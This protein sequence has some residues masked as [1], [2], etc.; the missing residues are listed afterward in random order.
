MILRKLYQL[1]RI[2]NNPWKDIEVLRKQQYLK[3]RKMIS[4]AYE[5]VPFYHK[6]FK[7]AGIRPEDIRTLADIKKIPITYKSD[8][9]ARSEEFLARGYD[10][11][12][13]RVRY[14][15]G[16][17]GNPHR[18]FFSK[19]ADDF[20]HATDL[21]SM[22]QN[23]YRL[24]HKSFELSHPRHIGRPTIP[25]RLGLHRV[26]LASIFET[27]ERMAC[28]IREYQPMF[29]K[30]YPSMLR[31]IAAKIEQGENLGVRKIFTT[32]ELL[33][34]SDRKLIMES[35]KADVIDL[36]GSVEFPRVAWECEKH[37]GY[38]IDIDS[39]VFELTKGGEVIE[40][41]QGD[42]TITGLYNK[43]MPL[44]RYNV[45]DIGR[46][47]RGLRCGC[48][49]S[50]PLLHSI[51]GRSNDRI[52]LPSGREVDPLTLYSVEDLIGVKSF[53]IIQVKPNAFQVIYTNLPGS[54]IVEQSFRKAIQNACGNEKVKVT[55]K[56]ADSLPRDPSGKFRAV[57]SRVRRQ[58]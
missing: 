27:P 33:S 56:R 7:E 21:R 25:Q 52:I 48:G 19:S 18:L 2:K 49:R 15:S 28:H 43:A 6:L 39:V 23:G 37:E 4:H 24:Y 51:R 22:Y 13:C 26:K 5:N 45:G 38:H 9:Q 34:R 17:T 36:Y 54:K 1:S 42:V 31:T 55:V 16:S 46:I 47:E 20:G 44:I 35:F 40:E 41:G 53:R 58:E 14:T 11:R 32:S 30:G 3:L 57:I 8:V 29:L 12:N 10:E 50:T